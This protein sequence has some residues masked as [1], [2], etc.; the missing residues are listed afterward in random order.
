[1]YVCICHAV[2]DEHIKEAVQGGVCDM[3]NLCCQ[4]KIASQC[5]KCGTHAK[6]VFS[7]QLKALQ[8][9]PSATPNNL[10]N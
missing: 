6:Q 3:K 4:L 10:S 8:K 9:K 7:S 5:G 2:T 1:M